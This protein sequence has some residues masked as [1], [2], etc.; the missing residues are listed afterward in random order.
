M[1]KE[2]GRVQHSLPPFFLMVLFMFVLLA[3][4]A[5]PLLAQHSQE[6]EEL[7]Q[8]D[9]EDRLRQ[10]IAAE[11]KSRGAKAILEDQPGFTRLYGD[12]EAM[13]QSYNEEIERIQTLIAE[14]SELEELM[15]RE[16][17]YGMAD[18]FAS[19]KDSLEAVID[20]RDLFKAIKRL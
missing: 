12:I 18:L 1:R 19:L 7:I 3:G 16:Q 6:T 2:L 11:M 20:N 9:F 5:S 8:V 13:V 4:S 17:R 15:V 14:I 10:N